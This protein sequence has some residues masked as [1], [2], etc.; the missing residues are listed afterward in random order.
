[1]RTLPAEHKG[2]AEK[3]VWYKIKWIKNPKPEK[4]EWKHVEGKIDL[5]PE[6]DLEKF[7][8]F[9]EIL[10]TFKSPKCNPGIRLSYGHT[11]EKEIEEWIK[12]N[13]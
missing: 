6:E 9:I 7:K 4:P 13:C 3:R 1:M 11:S 5:M 10:Q 12:N 8:G 2:F